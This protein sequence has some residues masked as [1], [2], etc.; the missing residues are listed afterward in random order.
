M[1][2][3]VAGKYVGNET[4]EKSFGGTETLTR[5]LI[6]GQKPELLKKFQIVSSR[7]RDLQEDLIRVFWA[8]DLPGDPEAN[9]ALTKENQAKF[10]K[11]VFVSNWQMQA[12]IDRYKLPWSKCVVIT[13]SI[14]PIKTLPKPDPKE[15]VRFIYHSTPHRGLN[16]LVSV[17]TA[18]AEKYPNI[19]LDV[20]SSFALYGWEQRDK[21]YADV[22]KVMDEHPNI[23]NHGTQPNSVVREALNQ[24]HVFAYPSIWAET[25][26]LCLLEAMSAE[27]VCIHSNYGALYETAAGWTHM[28]QMHEDLNKHASIL[29]NI[30]DSTIPQI[31][32]MLPKTGSAKSFID[33]FHGHDAKNREWEA[34]LT[35]LLHTVQDTTFPEPAFTY[36]TV[37]VLSGD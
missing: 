17:F 16:I 35:S 22:F 20:F 18:L 29:Y 28:Y 11:F 14:E 25:S 23:T 8:H 1:A 15:G 3:I 6:H 2:E 21:E 34:L 31:E 7:V 4:N 24:S 33:L 37:K 27:N 36:D 26:C 9:K 30:L 19:H 13:N 10:H 5:G 12:Y 32:L